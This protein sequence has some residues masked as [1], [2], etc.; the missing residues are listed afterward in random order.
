MTMVHSDDGMLS[1]H[2]RESGTFREI[3]TI[4]TLCCHLV[5][6]FDYN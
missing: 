1:R 4:I 3:P 6:K 2:Y 5:I